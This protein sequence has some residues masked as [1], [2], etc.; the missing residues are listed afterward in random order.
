[1]NRRQTLCG[2]AVILGAFWAP[3]VK[4]GDDP[5]FF[6][7]SAV[8]QS[9]V[10]Q[11]L[12]VNPALQEAWS[13]YRAS[14]QK[15]PQVTSLPDP[16][17]AFTHFARSVETRV[18]P[19]LNLLSLSQTFPWFGKL[20]LAGQTAA[21]EAAA[22]YH[23]YRAAERDVVSEVKAV[24]YDLA[25]LERAIAIN[26]EEKALL[27]HFERLAQNRYST[28]QGLQQ[29]VIRLQAELAQVENRALD[30]RGQRQV[31]ASRL[32]ALLSRDP[33]AAVPPADWVAPHP[34]AAIDRAALY[35]IAEENRDELLG[36]IS[37][38]E[39]GE[40]SIQLA[41]K[42]FWPNFTLSAGF[43]NVGDRGDP[44][45]R[46]APP[47]DNGK[48]AL[49]FSIGLNIPIWRD[50]YNARA[51]EAGE[52]LIAERQFYRKTLD[53]I[54]FA[55]QRQ[56]VRLE[57]LEQRIDLFEKVLIPQNEEAL[58]SVESAYVTGQAGVIDL[59]DS[60][61]T[62]LQLRLTAVRFQ[63]D[64]WIALAEMERALGTRFPQ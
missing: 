35:R 15:I 5:D 37:R 44:M 22:A 18:G 20:D 32:N 56:A 16:M 2:L 10:K 47:P 30:L 33:G 1:M 48:N 27:E 62:L 7:E 51:L 13:R 59:L 14:L 41:R 26:R 64:Y 11:A 45:G 63:A 19:Q 9:L 6:A 40:Q 4:A 12:D 55:V 42:D 25:Y 8:L 52:R 38:M 43:V 24:Y 57:T 21:R 39:H 3:G 17:L 54:R 58:G 34:V 29:G 60:E 28:G 50:K 61:R 46:L 49:S 53:Q 23:A 31:T 36:S